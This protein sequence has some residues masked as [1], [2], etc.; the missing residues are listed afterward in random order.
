MSQDQTFFSLAQFLAAADKFQRGMP[1]G[2]LLAFIL[3]AIDEG[4]SISEYARRADIHRSYMFRYVRIIG[5]DHIYKNRSRSQKITGFGWVEERPD[6]GNSHT[7][8]VFLTAKG[9]KIATRIS[10]AFGQR[11]KAL[12][13]GR[14]FIHGNSKPDRSHLQT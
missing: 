4:Q 11:P 8:N 1:V 2:Y 12:R 10:D 5:T 9:R 14:N 6:D 3:V 7:R 13:L